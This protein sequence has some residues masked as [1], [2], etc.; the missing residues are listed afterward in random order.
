[1]EKLLL[2]QVNE[3][4][5]IKKLAGPMHIKVDQIDG[6][7]YKE[8][9]GSL[10]H[11][12]IKNAEEYTGEL[13]QESLV[14]FCKVEEKKL[15]KLLLAFK[16]KNI[17]IDYKAIMTPTNSNWNILRLYFEMEREKKAYES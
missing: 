15:D 7:Y 2:F 3:F 4:E 12:A 1:M 5:Q 11:D 10:Y 14:V 8:T 16:K 13:P 6:K 17:A 9:L